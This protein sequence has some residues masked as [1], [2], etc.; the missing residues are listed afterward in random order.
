MYTLNGVLSGDEFASYRYTPLEL[1][2]SVKY[3]VKILI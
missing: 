1:R 2:L 3:F